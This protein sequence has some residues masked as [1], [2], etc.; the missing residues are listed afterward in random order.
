MKNKI[1]EISSHNFGEI[2]TPGGWV[3]TNII[4]YDDFTVDIIDYYREFSGLDE[5]IKNT[6]ID[7]N[8]FNQIKEIMEHLDEYMNNIDACDGTTWEYK[9]Y[10]NNEIYKQRK[11]GYMYGVFELENLKKILSNI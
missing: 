3:K 9:Y 1:F 2:C 10:K 6:I 11:L 7:E 4:I 5:K 8:T